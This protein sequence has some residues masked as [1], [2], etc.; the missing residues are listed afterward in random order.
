MDNNSTSAVLN[1]VTESKE[2]SSILKDHSKDLDHSSIGSGTTFDNDSSLVQ[3][4]SIESY[5]S[6]QDIENLSELNME[7]NSDLCVKIDQPEKHLETM[8]TYITFRVTTRVARIEFKDHEYVVRRRYNDFLWLRHKLLEYHPFCIIPPLPV[9]HSLIG[10]LDRYSK[11][12]ILA[13][14]KSLNMFIT[15]VCH[16]P[17][18][19]CDENLKVFLTTL[20]HDF[21]SYKKKRTLLSSNSGSLISL[22]NSNSTHSVLKNRHIEFDKMK[23]Y[24]V[25]LTSKLAS[26]EKISSRINKERGDLIIEMNNFHPIFTKWSSFEPHLSSILENIGKALERNSAAQNALVHNYNNNMGI[27]IKE[28]L[29]YI[30]VVQ[31]SLRRRES[32]QLAYESSLEEL[33]KMHNEKDKLL[34]TRECV[35]QNSTGFSL[36]RQS[37]SDEKLEKLGTNIPRLMKKVEKTQD[38]LEMANESLRSD[39]ECWQQEKRQC[40]KK[41][42]LDFVNKQINYYQTSVNAWEHVT[43]E[44]VSEGAIRKGTSNSK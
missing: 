13:R 4:P 8:E 10:Q 3:S 28:F 30:E 6:I 7:E 21:A 44:I 36:W 31:E 5:S 41:I 40:I 33:H 42:L 17:I 25:T 23:S 27:P 1:V 37:S 39:L 16:H 2:I 22:N 11:D 34:A 19:S 35:A 9:K 32:Y 38:N 15:R 12:F 18:L 43:N 20:P 29:Q 24:L 26:L 14:M